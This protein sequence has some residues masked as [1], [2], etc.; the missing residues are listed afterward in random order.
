MMSMIE[1]EVIIN[2]GV[3]LSA[4]VSLPL[5]LQGKRPAAILISGTGNGDR[6]GNSKEINLNLYRFLA[7]ELVK[8]GLI[9]LRYDKRGVGKSE[10]N[11]LTTGVNDLVDDVLSVI[12][13]L[14]SRDDVDHERIILV[15][16]SEGTILAT[17]AH[18]RSKVGGLVL[19]AGAGGCLKSA[20]ETQAIRSVAEFH[21]MKGLKG[22]LLKRLVTEKLVLKQ[23][24]KLFKLVQSTSKDVIKIQ[25]K[26]FPAKWL[27][28][29]LMY[30]DEHMLSLI[31][32]FEGPILVCEGD[33]DVQVNP[34]CMNDIRALNKANITTM[35][36]PNMNHICRETYK[37]LSV[38]NVMKQYKQ[39]SEQPLH[40]QLID[41]LSTW[42][43]QNQA[44]N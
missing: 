44:S 11:T 34:R 9:V 36:I 1:Q 8:M 17:L 12:N 22:A 26:P 7:N 20:M 32:R 6:D 19:I 15:G 28:E 41:T 24:E 18:E 33:K 25:F 37:P 43:I 40:P 10:G 42:I 35:L 29:H 21:S 3:S 31:N 38:M 16:H 5:A 23:Q 13:Y 39:E 30:S 4:T 2:E 14:K 27:R